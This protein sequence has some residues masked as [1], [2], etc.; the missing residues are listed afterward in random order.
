VSKDYAA[1][2]GGTAHDRIQK[3][4][5]DGIK[6]PIS[7]MDL[8]CGI[9]DHVHEYPHVDGGDPELLGR[10]LY[11]VKMKALFHRTFLAYPNLY[12][13]KLNE[14]RAKWEASTVAGLVIPTIGEM[15]CYC[16]NWSQKL[17]AKI[18]SGQSVELEFREK[19]AAAVTNFFEVKQLSA[20]YDAPMLELDAI[21]PPNAL[22]LFSDL[23]AAV[24]SVTAYLD[25]AQMY[26]NLLE[27][28]LLQLKGILDEFHRLDGMDKAEN[29]HVWNALQNIGT[30]CNVMLE[31][32]QNKAGGISEWTLPSDM[33]AAAI[34]TALYGDATHAMDILQ[35]NPIEDAFNVPAGYTVRYYPAKA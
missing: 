19:T 23:Q 2:P 20:T 12:P 27:S 10:K 4:A 33:S 29:Y 1:L 5:F 35:L 16:V 8:S 6:F 26:G 21:K 31:N 32:V 24:N 9:R 28:K 30:T 34:S 13:D 7:S 14:L 18:R 15:Q 22:S 17:E 3:A 11:T 25:T